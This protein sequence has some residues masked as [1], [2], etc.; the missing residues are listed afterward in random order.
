M[1]TRFLRRRVVAPLH[2]L[3]QAVTRLGEG[4]ISAR[5]AVEMDREFQDVAA[6]FNLMSERLTAAQGTLAT[7]NSELEQA[8]K[9]VREA[10]DELVQSEKLSAVGRMSAGLA[11]ELNNPLASVLGYAELL[12]AELQD[13]R[14]LSPELAR[15]HV[16]PIVREATRARQLVRS[17]LQFSRRATDEVGPV[18]LPDAM[19][20]VTDLRHGAFEQLGLQLIVEPFPDCA[21]LAEQQRLQGVFLNIMNNALHA[22]TPQQGGT[23]RV[24]HELHDDTIHVMFD[25]EGPGLSHPDRVFEPFFTTK[26]PGEGTGLGLAL[27]QRFVESFGGEIRAINRAEG[28]ARL[29]VALRLAEVRHPEPGGVREPQSGA[30]L[31]PRVVLVVDDEPE[32]RRLSGKVLRRL[33]VEVVE[34]A[35]AAAARELIMQRRVDVVV[36]DVRMPGE[37][38]VALYRWVER[39]QPELAR[40]FLFVT[41]DVDAEELGAIPREHPE[42]MLHKPFTLTDLMGRVSNLLG[43]ERSG[44]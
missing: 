44:G 40:R 37:S 10:R 26:Q 5:V 22:M 12:A 25:D 3:T 21:V 1:L 35:D 43:R 16:E 41:G 34:A 36:S 15:T 27:A 11:H 24:F 31:A 13:G 33:G 17:L 6:S 38:G 39:E 23:L 42:A 14:T 32:L 28:G 30:A 2:T 4:D 20:V 19:S 9:H 18:S 29:I 7:R 8:L